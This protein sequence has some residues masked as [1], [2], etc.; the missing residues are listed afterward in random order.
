MKYRIDKGSHSAYCLQFHFVQCTKFRRKVL[1]NEVDIALQEHSAEVLHHF[2]LDLL[3]QE[4]DRDH[5]HI[6]FG[7]KPT[8]LLSQFVN[9]FKTMTSRKLRQQFPELKRKV[10]RDAFWAPSYFLASVGQ[11]TLEDI[12]HYVEIQKD[13]V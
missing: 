13:R 4:T 7:S 12:R 10:R 1:V 6:L 9:S 8:V 11:V 2:G 5:I 3:A